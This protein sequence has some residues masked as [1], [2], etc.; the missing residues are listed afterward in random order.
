MNKR[1]RNLAD[2]DELVLPVGGEDLFVCEAVV[3]HDRDDR[4]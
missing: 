1:Q 3:V 4:G 2:P